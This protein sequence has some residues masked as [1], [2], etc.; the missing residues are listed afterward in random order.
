VQVPDWYRR[1]L[2]IRA[3]R[4][5]SRRVT[6]FLIAHPILAAAMQATSLISTV[7]AMATL[8]VGLLWIFRSRSPDKVI[9]VMG[10]IVGA[11]VIWRGTGARV[12]WEYGKYSMGLLAIVA[13]F[14]FG[15]LRKAQKMPLVYFALLVPSIFVLPFFDKD[16]ISFNLSGPFALAVTT[17][18][19]S[20]RRMDEP[21]FRRVLLATLAPILGLAALALFSTLTAESISFG[22]STKVTSAGIGPNQVSSILGLGALLAM[23]YVFIDRKRGQLRWFLFGCVF[24]LGAQSAMTFSRGGLVT[25]AGA[26]AAAGFFLLQDRRF[27][28]IVLV[29]GLLA[30]VVVFLLVLPALDSFTGGALSRRFSDRSLTGRDKIISADLIAFQENPVLGTGPGG[31]KHYHEITFRYSSAHTEYS[32]ALAEHGSAGL[33]ALL[34][35]FGLSLHR[36]LRSGPIASRAFSAAMT[37]WALLYMFHSAMRL[38]APA[39]VFA[40]GATVL[41]LQRT[42]QPAAAP[43]ALPRSPARRPPRPLPAARRGLHGPVGA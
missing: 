13:I 40:L 37:T 11:E 16:M 33:L 14:K 36:A 1:A 19:L 43:R 9:P 34:V 27:R 23:F 21:L 35:L 25:S 8:A 26:L 24:W 41:S 6:L 2:E 30:A 7:H 10:Y 3:E 31:S 42:P 22:A 20:T 28:G 39:L 29:R 4:R 12:F 5:Y 32:R 17:S 38:A 18:F 15:L